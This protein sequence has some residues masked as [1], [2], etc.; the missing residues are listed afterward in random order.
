[1]S[2]PLASSI[3]SS[4]SGDPVERGHRA[5]HFLVVHPHLGRDVGQDGRRVVEAG[6]V[7]RGAA[8]QHLGAFGDGVR[9]ELLHV[10]ALLLG[11]QRSDVGAVQH[12][13]AD[14]LADIC[15]ANRRSNSS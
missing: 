1:M 7:G 2:V 14:D 8:A 11:G 3:A 10:V 12:R 15:S 6:T 9:D 5:E 13:V 4:M